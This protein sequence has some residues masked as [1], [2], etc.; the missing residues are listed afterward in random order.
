MNRIANRRELLMQ[1]QKLV[2]ASQPT[3]SHYANVLAALSL[4]ASDDFDSPMIATLDERAT[5][6]AGKENGNA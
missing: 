5:A 6:A 1:V 2:H 4:V 3:P